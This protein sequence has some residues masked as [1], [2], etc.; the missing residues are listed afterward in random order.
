[1]RPLITSAALLIS[2]Q[3]LCAAALVLPTRLPR[4]AATS[5]HGPSCTRA[6]VAMMSGDSATSA[7]AGPPAG[8]W[9]PEDDPI[10]TDELWIVS[11]RVRYADSGDSEGILSSFKPFDDAGNHSRSILLLHATPPSEPE[12]QLLVDRLALSCECVAMAPLL[13]G[14][15]ER[16]PPPRLAQEGWQ[17][18]Q[19]LNR[20][21]GAE[22][23]AV[24]AVGPTALSVLALL[25]EGALD[26]HCAIA[27]CPG[28]GG[29]GGGLGPAD[30][31]RAA[32]ELSTPLLA[33]CS[34]AD[35]EGKAH[36]AALRDSLALNSRLGS[37]YF[38]AEFDGE[39]GEF[40]LGRSGSNSAADKAIALCQ[41]WVD[42][43]CAE[44]YRGP[45]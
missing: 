16:W 7:E 11:K 33:V 32:R 41:S 3:A 34:T 8:D 25:A 22:T 30:A 23:L 19:Y 17:A 12:L 38:V 29:G 20:A 39:A 1:M 15:L 9:R 45:G 31:A 44:N 24:V 21:C 42:A 2:T 5:C 13:R 40:V 4:R 35:G 26:A 10:Y 37:D 18:A 27:L 14:G 43:Y 28:R 36:A 6:L